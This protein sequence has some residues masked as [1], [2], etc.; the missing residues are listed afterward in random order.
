MEGVARRKQNQLLGRADDGTEPDSPNSLITCTTPTLPL[1][2]SGTHIRSSNGS[3][4][5]SGRS[6]EH[7]SELQSRPHLVCRLLLE[8]KNNICLFGPL[9]LT[10]I[11]CRHSWPSLQTRT[12]TTRP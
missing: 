1:V 6:E 11:P 4:A 8:K 5:H 2:L 10:T 7:T 3:N 9:C 12:T